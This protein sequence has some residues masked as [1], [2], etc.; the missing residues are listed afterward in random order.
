MISESDVERFAREPGLL[1]ELCRE[2]V[3]WLDNEVVDDEKT[4]MKAQLREIA[5]A[6]DNLER[7]GIPVPEPLRAEKIRLVALL[8]GNAKAVHALQSLTDG[9]EGVVNDLKSRSGNVHEVATEKKQRSKRSKLP[10]TDYGTLRQMIVEVLRSKGGRARVVEVVD[11]VGERLQGQLLPG[12]LE[13]RQDGKTPVWRNNV[14][15]TRLRMVQDG[16]LRNDSPN[17][18]WELSEDRR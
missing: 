4:A 17:G 14:Q 5:R 15:W 8:E 1:V 11:G 10:K 16:A 18:I 2:V 3:A 7:H 12:D 6:V 9:L 13:V